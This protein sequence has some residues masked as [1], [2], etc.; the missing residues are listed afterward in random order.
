[1][2]IDLSD[3][4]SEADLAAYDYPLAGTYHV[5]MDRVN[6]ES[7]DGGKVVVD[8]EVLAG[9]TP[10]QA[11]KFHR[12]YFSTNEAAMKRL[13]KLALVAGLIRP[14]QRGEVDFQQIVGRQLIIELVDHEYE[15][16]GEKR[17]AVQISFLG[18]HSMANKK[19]AD[20]PRGKS[21]KPSADVQGN[22]GAVVD[23]DDFGDL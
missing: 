13:D 18:M 2:K 21:S 4:T 3:V 19:F 8:F 17:T 11:G 23:D 15:K 10:E 12:E 1:M 20:A 14:G 7:E 22:E 16:D 6:D 5:Q 9:T